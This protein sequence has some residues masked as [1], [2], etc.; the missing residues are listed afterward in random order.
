MGLYQPRFHAEVIAEGRQ[1]LILVQSILVVCDEQS[2][3]SINIMFSLATARNDKRGT[4]G[5]IKVPG[6][7]Q[8]TGTGI[9]LR[10]AV[11]RQTETAPA[12]RASAVSVCLQRTGASDAFP[13]CCGP[14]TLPSSNTESFLVRPVEHPFMAQILRATAAAARERGTFIKAR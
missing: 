5:P 14:T 11:C 7:G 9:G 12:L 6:Q 2:A 1:P 3:Y 10:P 13:A 8:G 4:F